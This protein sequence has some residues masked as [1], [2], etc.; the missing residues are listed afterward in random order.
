MTS[1]ELVK[2]ISMLLFL[3]YVF[4]E[5]LLLVYC[6]RMKKKKDDRTLNELTEMDYQFS[7]KKKVK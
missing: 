2:T 7:N 4:K 6:E 3:R 5:I 1:M